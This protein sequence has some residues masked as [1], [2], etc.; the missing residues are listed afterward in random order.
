[1]KSNPDDATVKQQIIDKYGQE[2]GE[3]LYQIIKE[4]KSETVVNVRERL[5]ELVKEELG[6]KAAAEI[7]Y[8]VL[9]QWISIG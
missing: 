5:E 6:E 7:D 9:M 1:M 8:D 2:V 4:L 3:K